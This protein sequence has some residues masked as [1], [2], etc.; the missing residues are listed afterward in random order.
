LDFLSLYSVIKEAYTHNSIEKAH[1]IL[2]QYAMR[3]G[4]KD[5]LVV[6]IDGAQAIEKAETAKTRQ[7]IRDKAAVQCEKSLSE[8]EHRINSNMKPRK[9]H[10]TDVKSSLAATFYWTLPMHCRP[11][12]VVV[13]SDS[14][15]MAYSTVSTLWRPISKSL[16]LVYKLE[17]VRKTLN[18]S[19]AQLTALAVTSGNDYGKNVFSL[20]VATNYSI[21]KAIPGK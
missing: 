20:G 16:I 11:D 21:I 4:T 7:A 8:L 9:R 17:D 18:F 15:M 12:D 19:V 2:E 3:F 14:D 1:K 6:Y 10:F 5:L 13:S